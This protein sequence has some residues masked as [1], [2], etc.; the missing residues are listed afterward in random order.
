MQGF[1]RSFHCRIYCSHEKYTCA[2]ADGVKGAEEEA[3]ELKVQEGST[4]IGSVI[5]RF[6][7][8][9]GCTALHLP[10]SLASKPEQASKQSRSGH[11]F[12]RSEI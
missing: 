10:E 3:L 11:D 8:L 6:P 5:K 12:A 4:L 9:T 1:F 7:F 2:A